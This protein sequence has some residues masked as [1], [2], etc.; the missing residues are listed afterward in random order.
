MNLIQGEY[1]RRD[2]P[3]GLYVILDRAISGLDHFTAAQRVLEGGARV[4]Q[5]RDKMAPFE[6]LVAVGRDLVQAANEYDALLIVND[7]PYL[8]AEMDA[9]GV[10]IGQEDIPADI[11][12]EIIG[13]DRLLGL[14][15][16]NRRQARA[17]E[18]QPVDYIG[19]GPIF[20]TLTKKST[21][22]IM[23]VE[24]VRWASKSIRLPQVAI[25]GVTLERIPELREAGGQR[26]AVIS[27]LMAAPDITARTRE[28]LDA[29]ASPIEGSA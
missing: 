17:A 15:T 16:H 18:D 26:A 20:R 25:G 28:F 3:L 7:N 21:N 29:F 10:H 24:F 12:R 14:S 5:L 11:A 8:A 2:L 23:S 1:H 27:D 22:P 6:E 19:L 9:H 13:P 4:I